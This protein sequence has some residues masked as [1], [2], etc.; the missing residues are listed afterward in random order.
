MASDRSNVR[1]P[2]RLHPARHFFQQTPLPFLGAFTELLKAT[3]SF[4][5]SFLPSAWNSSA[6]TGWIFVKFNVGIFLENLL[7]K[8]KFR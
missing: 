7:G 4:A 2:V 1:S 3:I 6:P 5:M 8:F